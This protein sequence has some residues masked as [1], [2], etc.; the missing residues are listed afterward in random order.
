[1]KLKKNIVVLGFLTILLGACS[2]MDIPPVN[3]LGDKDIFNTK[4]GVTAYMARLYSGLPVEDFRY[5]YNEFNKGNNY[6]EA[7]CITGEAISRSVPGTSGE[8][9]NYWSDAYSLIR[10]VNFMLESFPAYAD[11]FNKTAA[12]HYLGEA[13]FIRAFTYFALVKRYG[14]VPLV[15]KVLNY[16]V[17][18]LE[19][20]Q[21]PRNSEEEVWDFVSSELDLAIELMGTQGDNLGRADKYVALALKSRAM[22]YAGSIARYN[23]VSLI[24][25]GKRLCGVPETRANDYFKQSY[26]AAKLL[27]GNFSLYVKEW[28]DN[29]KQAQFTNYVNLFF[30][31]AKGSKENIFVR[32]YV[33]PEFVHSWDNLNVSLQQMAGNG[34]GAGIC[35]TLDF[36]EMFDGFEK[37]ANG[38]FKML[39]ENGKYLLFDEIMSPFANAEPRLRASIILPGDVFKGEA[40][41]VRRGIYIGEVAG[42]IPRLLPEGSPDSYTTVRQ[43]LRTSSTEGPSGMT[44]YTLSNGEKMVPAGKSGTVNAPAYGTLSGFLLRKYMDEKMERASIGME[45]ST[46]AW[47]ELRYAEVLLN[48][49]ESAYELYSAG[50]SGGVDYLTDAYSCINEIRKRAGARL[51]NSAGDLNNVN[52]IRIERRKELAFE[53]KIWWDLKR[54]RIADTEQ[55]STIYRILMPFYA[56]KAGKYFF[57]ARTDERGVRY[58]FDSRWYYQSIPSNLQINPNLVQNPGY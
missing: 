23:A 8:T 36:V 15:D 42:G 4:E 29:D 57:D 43:R 14:G 32:Y 5:S 31:V 6:L 58:T 19:E 30:D 51:L 54:W 45:K 46:Q 9:N 44:P 20:T 17:I 7:Q 26:D 27:E 40:T 38:K 12:D 39:D 50:A 52:I 53:N 47:I 49:A 18:S 21:K 2:D 22:L 34:S 28:K 16:P 11:N 41:E 13:H 24:H 48:R 25:E 56:D 55:N 35:P 33:Y 3:I 10:K 37:D 1:M